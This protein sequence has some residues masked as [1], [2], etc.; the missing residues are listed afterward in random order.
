M[1]DP[2]NPYRQPVDGTS[3]QHRP[4]PFSSFSSFPSYPASTPPPPPPPRTGTETRTDGGRRRRRRTVVIAV[5]TVAAVVAGAAVTAAVLVGRADEDR[6]PASAADPTKP[7]IAGW[8]TVINPKHG[9]AFDVPP[10]WEVLS[11]DVFSG[12]TDRKDPDKVL[13]GHTA[14]AF[15]KSKW[16]SID[17]NGDG[18]VTDVR[19][20][21]TGTKGAS[22]AKDTA[23]IA[24]KSAPT[25]VYAAYT[26]PD[27]SV[28]TWDKPKEFTTKSGVRGSYVK[29]RSK[30]A[31]QPNRCAGDGQAVVFGFKNSRGDLVAWDFYGRTG[32]PGAV[33]DALVM[34]IMSTVRLAGDPKEPSP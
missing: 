6:T 12:H 34:R 4:Q 29:A 3:G 7:L 33:D 9:T 1:N 14:P 32:V 20:G 26:Q 24:E 13:I 30:G 22:G 18:Q 10:Q 28:V 16:C 19:L 25:W 27:K 31:A 8:K 17:A 5:C 11:P 2:Y 15:Y 23:E 21:N